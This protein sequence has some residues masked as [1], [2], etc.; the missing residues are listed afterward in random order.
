MTLSS[1]RLDLLGPTSVPG[2]GKKQT[3]EVA[4][5]LAGLQTTVFRVCGLAVHSYFGDGDDGC[6]LI[7]VSV[8][9]SAPSSKAV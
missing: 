7:R 4:L 6:F 1:C 8:A 9:L 3:T 5:S 2:M